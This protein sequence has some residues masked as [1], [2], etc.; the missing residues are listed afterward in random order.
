[1]NLVKDY[2]IVLA[3]VKD[4]ERPTHW[5]RTILDGKLCVFLHEI[6]TGEHF[7]FCANYGTED[8]PDWHT[9]TTSRVQSFNVDGDGEKVNSVTV[10]TKN[11]I[12]HFT[13]LEI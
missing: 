4:P 3:D 6:M 9:I 10:E 13:R 11:T 2:Y 8:Y 7:F 12:Y 1:M 5:D